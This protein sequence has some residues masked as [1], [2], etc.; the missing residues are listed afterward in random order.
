M[1]TAKIS[2]FQV[3]YKYAE[4]GIKQQNVPN[5]N[6]N[7]TADKKQLSITLKLLLYIS[8]CTDVQTVFRGSKTVLFSLWYLNVRTKL[9]SKKATM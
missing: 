7:I 1:F 9:I 6:I 2:F 5:F 3:W 4:L 8:N